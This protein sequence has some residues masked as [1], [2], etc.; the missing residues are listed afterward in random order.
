MVAVPKAGAG[1]SGAVAGAGD[2]PAGEA[3]EAGDLWEG[4]QAAAR[5]R[6]AVDDDAEVGPRPHNEEKTLD[7]RS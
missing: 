4:A 3:A 5:A 1:G 7:R 2:A 6:A